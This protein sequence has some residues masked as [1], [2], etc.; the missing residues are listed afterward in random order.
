MC[1]AQVL[2]S[3]SLLCRKAAGSS[4]S[5][6][7]G[8]PSSSPHSSSSTPGVGC[9]KSVQIQCC[10]RP[11]MYACMHRSRIIVC[12]TVELCLL[13]CK[14]HQLASQVPWNLLGTPNG[15][16]T[17]ACCVQV[18]AS[19]TSISPRPSASTPG[20]NTTPSSSAALPGR[21][22]NSGSPMVVHHTTSSNH[23]QS[24]SQLL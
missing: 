23:T 21:G 20:A 2:V 4:S 5:N 24:H 12:I 6:Q 15:S 22:M 9:R 19:I 14:R 18:A 3:Q 10:S 1:R 7:L 8:D 11:P 16:C 13:H 17:S